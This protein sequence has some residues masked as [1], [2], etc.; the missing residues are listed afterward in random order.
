[1]RIGLWDR[2]L[3]TSNSIFGEKSYTDKAHSYFVENPEEHAL[4][5]LM[6]PVNVSLEYIKVLRSS[7][8]T[9]WAGLVLL[10]RT[11]LKHV[12]DYVKLYS[13]ALAAATLTRR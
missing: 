2:F 11:Y 7:K 4:N 10:W 12:E 13:R 3:C 9:D 1:M 5:F 8:R 6:L